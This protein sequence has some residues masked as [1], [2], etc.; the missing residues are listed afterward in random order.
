MP[1]LCRKGGGGQEREGESGVLEEKWGGGRGGWR[2][3][4]SLGGPLEEGL[5]FPHGS[6]R[7]NTAV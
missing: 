3:L 2:C 5:K 1:R 7:D 4:F 6:C